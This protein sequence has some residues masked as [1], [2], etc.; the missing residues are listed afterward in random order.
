MHLHDVHRGI[1]KNRSRKR[2]GRGLGS[3]KGKT[4][5][6][7]HKGH[8]SRSGFFARVTF[9]GSLPLFRHIPKRGFTNSFA[10]TV[11]AVNVGALNEAF[12]EGAEITPESIRKAGVYCGRFDEIKVLGDG[13]LNKK[14][15]ISAHRFSGSARTKIE[16]AGGQVVVLPPRRTPD[17]RVAAKRSEK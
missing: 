16:A 2:L 4:C 3:G 1:T 13:E 7:G 11:A 6:K 15:K 9:Q 17:E 5:G 8:R 12:D 14:L 10:I